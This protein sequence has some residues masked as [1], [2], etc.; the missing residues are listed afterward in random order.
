MLFDPV[1]WLIIGISF[2]LSMAA[3]WLVK[4]AFSRAERVPLA[5]HA[6]GAQIAQA[7]LDAEGIDD[8][9]VVETQGFLS[10]H[11]N[12][13]SK[14][15]A[16]SAKVYHGTNAAAAGVAAHE[17]G[18][19]IQHAR[20]YFPL[21][22]RSA[23]VP[24]ANIG[25][26]LGPWIIIAGIMLGAA[27]GAGLGQN[28]AIAGVAIFGAAVAFSVITLPVEFNASARARERLASLGLTSGPAEDGAVRG[29]LTAAGLTYVAAAVSSI[30]M[31]LYWAA[32]A[33]LL[34]SRDE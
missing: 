4:K 34:G 1:Y 20:G 32:Q 12:P 23:L 16:L 29:V 28:I 11:Y 7:I 18:H 25:S 31:L 26:M 27:Q 5:R 15:L 14:T 3:S 2:V 17:V 19:A 8:V 6:K 24:V 10:D 30:M 22:A 13:M 21:W 9:Q 33:G